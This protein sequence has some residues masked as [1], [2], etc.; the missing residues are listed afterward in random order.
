MLKAGGGGALANATA[1]TDY[2]AGTASLGT[3]I[4][5]STGGTGALSIA[6]SGTDIKTINL[7][8]I[9]GAGNLTVS[10]INWL[11]AWDSVPPYTIYDPNDAVSYGGSS[12]IC[13]LQTTAAGELPTNITYWN[14]LAIQG[15]AGPAGVSGSLDTPFTNGSG[16]TIVVAHNFNAYPVV[17]VYD[18]NGAQ[19]IPLSVTNTSTDSV[20]IVLAAAIPSGTGHIICTIGGSPTSVITKSTNYTLL[21]TDA[22]VLVTAACTITLPALPASPSIAGKIYNIKDMALSGVLIIVDG[23][24]ATIDGE[25]TKTLIAQYTTLTVFTDNTNW[26]II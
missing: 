14:P 26:Y 17:A 1:G 11:G 13:I 24:G 8:S 9:L 21:D 6:V 25:A 3:G 10:T 23:N 16:T 5:K 15:N 20:T 19:L 22:L 18:Q 4:L 2:S 7:N 12:Y